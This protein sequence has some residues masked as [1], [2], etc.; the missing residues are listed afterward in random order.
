M[1]DGLFLRPYAARAIVE[2][3]FDTDHLNVWVIFRF[4]MDQALKPA[5]N[6]WT[7]NIDGSDEVITASTWQDAWTLLLTI[8]GITATPERVTLTYDGPS[9]NLRITWE[10]Q[11]E[12]FGPILSTGPTA[13]PYGSFKGNEINWQQ[14]AAQTVWYTIS[15]TDITAGQTN[16]TTF[17]N[18]QELEIAVAGKYN[19]YYY[20]TAEISI[21]GK[22]IKTAIE[23]NGTEQPDGQ[24]HHHF[25]RANEEKSWSGGGILDLAV[26]DLVSVGTQSPDAGTPTI[27]VD[28][29]GLVLGKYQGS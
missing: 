29:M 19:V 14:V 18:N 17:Q 9:I 12:P 28:H 1:S 26:D 25:G 4:A 24:C 15:D 22:H 6:K 8:A 7:C 20:I 23:I 21:A 3:E 16:K 2:H 27:T 5:L 13:I 10:K 11:W